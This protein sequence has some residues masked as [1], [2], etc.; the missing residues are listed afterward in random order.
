M[1]GA[2]CD[3]NRALLGTDPKGEGRILTNHKYWLLQVEF[4][5][6]FDG[7]FDVLLD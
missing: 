4:F 3:E 5:Y 7:F 2:D 6:L 1:F